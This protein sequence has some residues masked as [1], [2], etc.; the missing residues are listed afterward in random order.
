MGFELGK[1]YKTVGGWKALIVYISTNLVKSYSCED[2]QS[3]RTIESSIMYVVH[4]PHSYKESAPVAHGAF[5][6]VLGGY[7]T[8]GAPP[9]YGQPHPADLT[10]ELWEE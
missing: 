10:N 3:I 9:L 6:K 8:V 4:E 7:L 1:S 5:G 2:T